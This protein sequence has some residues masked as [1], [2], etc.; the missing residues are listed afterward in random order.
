MAR[1]A[2]PIGTKRSRPIQSVGTLPDPP[3]WLDEE[4]IHEW[5]RVKRILET[6]GLLSAEDWAILGSY[7]TVQQLLRMAWNSIGETGLVISTAN[8]LEMPAPGVAISKQMIDL[9][10]KLAARLGLSPADRAS[11][12]SSH[13]QKQA[14]RQH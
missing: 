14:T 7:C 6:R 4:S 1:I 5:H 8:G 9:G 11:C 3:K 2:K 10:I 13:H 12:G